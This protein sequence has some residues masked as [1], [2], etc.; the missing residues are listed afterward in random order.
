[1]RE[2]DGELAAGEICVSTPVSKLIRAL[3]R[4]AG[5]DLV[6]LKNHRCGKELLDR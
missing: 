3:E 5:E 4:N 1:L 6:I 2:I